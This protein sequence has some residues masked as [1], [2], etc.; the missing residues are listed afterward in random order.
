MNILLE[1]LLQTMANL[2]YNFYSLKTS[3]Y[4]QV[5]EHT[6]NNVDLQIRSIGFPR[7]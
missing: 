5:Y 2:S 7:K 3:F 1:K 4:I 6:S